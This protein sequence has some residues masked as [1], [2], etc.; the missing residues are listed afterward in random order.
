MASL[1]ILSSLFKTNLYVGVVCFAD[2][3]FVKVK[4][5]FLKVNI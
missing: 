2:G 5:M 4:S 1:H 3:N